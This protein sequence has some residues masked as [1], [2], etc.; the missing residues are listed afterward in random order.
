MNGEISS[1]KSDLDATKSQVAQV[2]EKLQMTEKELT[3][4]ERA[5]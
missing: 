1:I 3:A 5:N 4:F 2:E